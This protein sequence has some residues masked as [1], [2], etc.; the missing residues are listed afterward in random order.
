MGGK[1]R[2]AKVVGAGSKEPLNKLPWNVRFEYWPI[3]A[4][5]VREFTVGWSPR[6]PVPMI[7]TPK[8]K[9]EQIST[10]PLSVNP[11]TAVIWIGSV[12]SK[13]PREYPPQGSAGG[14]EEF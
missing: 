5:A 3:D 6:N 11:G 7:S 12:T 8:F 1:S 2:E 10:L 14:W 13:T 9:P 4:V